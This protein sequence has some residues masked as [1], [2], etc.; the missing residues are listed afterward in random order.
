MKCP[1]C[2]NVILSDETICKFCGYHINDSY[3]RFN[4]FGQ[5]INNGHKLMRIISGVIILLIGLF[6]LFVSIG[7]IV[8]N[9][10]VARNYIETNGRYVRFDEDNDF[11]TGVYEYEVDGKK[12]E[13]RCG[14][15]YSDIKEIPQECMI[16]Y[17]KN[18]PDKATDS[19]DINLTTLLLDLVFVIAAV[20]VIFY[21][22]KQKQFSY[23]N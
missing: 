17:D 18:N 7:G 12:Y 14:K 1:N 5:T 16:K 22:P 4:K 11:Y 19:I 23:N 3:V 15:A 10:T 21:K 13:K 6:G 9:N 8:Y 2:N 20:F